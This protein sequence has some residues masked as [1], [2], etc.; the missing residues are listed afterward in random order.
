[1][2]K[3]YVGVSGCTNTQN[4]WFCVNIKDGL[5]IIKFINV[6]YIQEMIFIKL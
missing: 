5:R 3:R 6:I 4:K 1:V 2:I